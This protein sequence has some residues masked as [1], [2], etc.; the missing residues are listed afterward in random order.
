MANPTG[1][2]LWQFP[3]IGLIGRDDL[4]EKKV[5]DRINDPS[6]CFILKG[7]PGCGKT[8]LLEWAYEHH[9]IN[10]VSFINGRLPL[11]SIY[12]QIIDDWN[13]DIPGPGAKND[14]LA[15]VILGCQGK[16]LYIDD[17]DKAKPQ[18]LYTLKILGQFHKL[19]GVITTGVKFKDELKQLMVG[20]E[21]IKVSKLEK[22]DATRLAGKIALHYRKQVD[23]VEIVNRA[24]GKPANIVNLI[25][26][27][28]IPKGGEEFYLESELLDISPIF[29]ILLVLL[30]LSR[31]MGR[32]VQATDLAVIGSLAML[33]RL[34][35]MLFMKG[36]QRS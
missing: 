4:L 2:K 25:Q 11:S 36:G 35:L 32:A 29:L 33:A 16:T 19:N 31:M 5:F 20:R 23:L 26:T 9:S 13:L 14:D 24:K 34:F 28:E 7:V 22:K 10:D 27:G 3:D 6:K 12:R 21:T 18:V 1:I 30:I 8:A 15:E 17:L